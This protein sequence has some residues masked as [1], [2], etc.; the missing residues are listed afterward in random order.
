MGNR[1]PPNPESTHPLPGIYGKKAAIGLLREMVE[2]NDNRPGASDLPPADCKK[3]RLMDYGLF[4][5]W[6][7]ASRPRR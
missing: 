5:G 1:K 4:A 7:S 6:I 2:E 3:S